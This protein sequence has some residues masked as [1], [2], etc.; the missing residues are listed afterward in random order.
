[1]RISSFTG[2][3]I[4]AVVCL[5]VLVAVGTTLTSVPVGH[6]CLLIDPLAGTVISKPKIGPV[7]FLKSPL[8]GKVLIKYTVASLGMWG[9]GTDPY[10]DFPAI[11]CFSRE[12]IELPI[13]IAVR[14]SLDTNKLITLYE[15]YPSLNWEKTTIASIARETIRFVIKNYSWEEVRDQRDL[16]GT[17]IQD[18]IREA[19]AHEP[20]LGGAIIN[21]EVDF[22]NVGLPRTIVEAVEAKV[23]A[24]ELMLKAEFERQQKLIEANATAQ[25][26]LIEAEGEARAQIARATGEAEAIRKIIE[27]VGSDGWQT[28]YTLQKLKEISPNIDVLIMGDGAELLYQLPN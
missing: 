22:R 10:A 21:V 24:K 11:K 16:V 18:A 12:G 23:A 7:W 17:Q 9:N 28:Y 8:Q 14:Y 25:A 19:L 13:D 27:I 5:S 6:A 20:S 1:M 15:N 4:L 26:M 3:F 2:L